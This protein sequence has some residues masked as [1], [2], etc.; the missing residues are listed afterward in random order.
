M[1]SEQHHGN[2][3]TASSQPSIQSTAI[4]WP[5]KPTVSPED[6]LYESSPAGHAGPQIGLPKEMLDLPLVGC[7][8]TLDVR[9]NDIKVRYC[10]W[11]TSTF[12]I[13]L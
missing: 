2:T 12:L 4:R 3:L 5:S 10:C 7:L 9:S 13:A 6:D 11:L 8:L 1:E